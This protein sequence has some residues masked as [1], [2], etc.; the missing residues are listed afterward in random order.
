VCVCLCICVYVYMYVCWW[1]LPCYNPHQ[2]ISMDHLKLV[3]DVSV[4]RYQA[5]LDGLSLA[6]RIGCNFSVSLGFCC[7]WPSFSCV[8]VSCVCVS[9]VCVS[10]VCVSCVSCVSFPLSGLGLKFSGGLSRRSCLVWWLLEKVR[11]LFC[12]CTWVPQREFLKIDKT[13]KDACQK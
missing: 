6:D 4:Y 9:C 8:C 12:C 2:T 5:F 13:R 11:V 10:C 7:D 3:Q 1:P